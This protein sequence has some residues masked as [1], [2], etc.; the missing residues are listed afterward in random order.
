M[1]ADFH[2]QTFHQKCTIH[3]HIKLC[4]IPTVVGYLML[5]Q[6]VAH[7]F[8]DESLY[9]FYSLHIHQ[10]NILPA[11]CLLLA[12]HSHTRAYLTHVLLKGFL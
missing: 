9:N 11:S 7:F 6:Q 4:A 3:E 1:K 12:S 10:C 8:S 2:F 5:F